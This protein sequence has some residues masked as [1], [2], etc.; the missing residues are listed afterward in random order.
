MK[1]SSYFSNAHLQVGELLSLGRKKRYNYPILVPIQKQTP[2]KY[3]VSCLFPHYLFVISSHPLHT[4]W[5]FVVR[6]ELDDLWDVPEGERSEHLEVVGRFKK[7][8]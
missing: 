3:F 8:M 4:I 5:T 1:H 2:F 6:L 7:K